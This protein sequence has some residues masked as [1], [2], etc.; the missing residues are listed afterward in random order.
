MF[1]NFITV[2]A[3]LP[4]CTVDSDCPS[5]RACINEKCQEPCAISNP[6][7]VFAECNTLQHRPVCNC[8][9][10]WAGNPQ[11]HCYKRECFLFCISAR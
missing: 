6:C 4:E 11:I 5:S 1:P 10:G 7:G 8:P 9:D 3:A 2:Q